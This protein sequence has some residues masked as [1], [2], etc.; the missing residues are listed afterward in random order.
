MNDPA[1]VG[2]ADVHSVMVSFELILV[3]L[4]FAQKLESAF[5]N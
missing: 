2:V 1:I 5:S 3:V 4:L